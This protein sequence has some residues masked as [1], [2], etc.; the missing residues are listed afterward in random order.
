MSDIWYYGDGE[1]SVGP[2]SLADPAKTLSRVANARDV[3]VCGDCFE[4]WQRA[5]TVPGLV[6][7]LFEPPP[8]L[9]PPPLPSNLPNQPPL[10]PTAANKNEHRPRYQETR[11]ETGGKRRK[12]IAAVVLSAVVLIA[13]QYFYNVP[14]MEK[15]RTAQ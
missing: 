14:Q 15:Q 12:I 3:L 11:I 2:L 13:W 10:V 7:L 1:K 9:L 4:Q 5:E 6:A 8:P